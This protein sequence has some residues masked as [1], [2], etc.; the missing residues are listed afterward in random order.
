MTPA[1]PP[2]S[3]PYGRDRAMGEEVEVEDDTEGLE[4]FKHYEVSRVIQRRD[5][6]VGRGKTVTE[7]LV[8]WTDYPNHY[9]VWM[10]SEHLRADRLIEEFEARRAQMAA[11]RRDMLPRDDDEPRLLEPGELPEPPRRRGLPKGAKGRTVPDRQGASAPMRPPSQR[12]AA[13]RSRT[14]M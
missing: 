9:N 5:R 13:L 7:Y 3:D 14:G 11:L 12:Q 2:L 8:K 4:A 6:Q 1:T 10:P